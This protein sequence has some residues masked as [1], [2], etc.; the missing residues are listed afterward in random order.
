MGLVGVFAASV[1]GDWMLET[2]YGEAFVA[3]APAFRFVMAA[4]VI[5]YMGSALGFIIMATGKFGPLVW[6]SAAV[7]VITWSIAHVAVPAWGLG[8]AAAAVAGGHVVGILVTIMLLLHFGRAKR[9]SLV[10]TT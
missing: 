8:G 7:V 5:A 4:M 2:L 1:A 10:Q 9:M 6:P 3:A